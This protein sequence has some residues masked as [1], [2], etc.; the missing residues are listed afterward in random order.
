MNA[1]RYADGYARPSLA[2]DIALFTV[3]NGELH[4]LLIERGESPFKGHWAL[5]GG[6]VQEYEPIADCARRE[7]GEETGFK[8]ALLEQF[9]IFDQ[10][11]RDPRGWY[12]SV[13]FMAMTSE[14]DAT[15]KAG[16]DAADTRWFPVSH[17]PDRLAFDHSE[18]IERALEELG[19]RAGRFDQAIMDPLFAMLPEHF[20]LS[21]LQEAFD[22]IHAG[23]SKEDKQESD[24]R[25]FRKRVLALPGLQAIPGATQRGK[26]RPAQLYKYNTDRSSG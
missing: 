12:I 14:K 3:I 1:S 2:A 8:A 26:H 22:A 20:T 16:T 11:G 4:L 23:R 15:I 7:L 17:L 9:G 6:F 10:K 25:N 19:E 5:P 13:A 18:I 24:K 21:Q